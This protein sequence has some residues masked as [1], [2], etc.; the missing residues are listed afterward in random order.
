MDELLTVS[1]VA[2]LLRVHT[3][4]VK[5]IDREYL[6]F[7]RVVARGDRRYRRSDVERYVREMTRRFK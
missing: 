5:S 2:E 6:P 7:I 4:T 1:E 3:H